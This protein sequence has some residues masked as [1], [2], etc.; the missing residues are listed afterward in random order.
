MYFYIS[1]FLQLKLLLLRITIVW[2][3][4]LDIIYPTRGIEFHVKGDIV[5]VVCR[6]IRAGDTGGLLIYFDN[7]RYSI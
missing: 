6:R 4:I 2:E 7:V 1:N 5:N 3:Y